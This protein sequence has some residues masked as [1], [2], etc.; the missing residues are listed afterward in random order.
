M[1]EQKSDFGG[2][3]WT[4]NL[5]E[6]DREVARLAIIC[7]VRILDPG[8]LERVLQNDASVCGS[9]N[10]AAFDKL[11]NALMMHYKVRDQAVDA[12]GEVVTQRVVAELVERLRKRIGDLLGGQG[13][14]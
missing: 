6:I 11:R 1:A 7:K 8:V 5:D 14:G 10:P 3:F 2:A 4:R 13:L 9:K 12:M